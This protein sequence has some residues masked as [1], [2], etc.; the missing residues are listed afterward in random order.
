MNEKTPGQIAYEAWRTWH[1]YPERIF[2]WDRATPAEVAKWN[3]I[4]EAVASAVMP[5]WSPQP[6][7]GERS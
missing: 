4:G 3:F 7:Q 5:A 6:E 2:T 1:G